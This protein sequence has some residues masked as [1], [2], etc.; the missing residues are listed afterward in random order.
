MENLFRASKVKLRRALRFIDEVEVGL[1]AHDASNPI[2]VRLDGKGGMEITLKEIDPDVLAALGDAVHNMRAALDV[3]ASELARINDESDD[4][5]YFPFAKSKEQFPD[6]IKRKN[7]HKAGEDAVA[8]IKKFEPY[9]DGNR[10]LRAIHD[11]DIQ[12]KHTGILVTRRTIR[13]LNFTYRLDEVQSAPIPAS[14]DNSH[15]F[16]EG[17]LAGRPLIKTLRELVQLVDG[18]IE[19]F[20]SMVELR[21]VDSAAKSERP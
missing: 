5:V 14:G 7:F 6:Q 8:L 13:N 4:D 20:A 16:L 21:Q 15:E 11:L 19:E 1:Q 17:P 18:I 12:D 10:M 2:G 3:M 9:S